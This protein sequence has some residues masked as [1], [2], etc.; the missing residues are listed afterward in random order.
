MSEE[1]IYSIDDI[2]LMLDSLLKEPKQWWDGY[3]SDRSRECPFFVNIPDE[4]LDFYFGDGRMKRGRVLE[5]GCGPGRNAI[6]LA[7][8]GCN[9]DAVDISSQAIQWAQ[10]RARDSGLEI[11]FVCQS[12]F[13]L[14]VET[15]T[16]DIVYD[17]GCFHH[18]PPH[19]RMSYIELVRNALKPDGL[20]GLVCF[21]LEGGFG[22]S[23]WEVYR[24]R[25]LGGGLGYSEERLWRTFERQFEILEFRR[26][27]EMESDSGLFGKAFLW[28]ILMRQRFLSD[29]C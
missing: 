4:N 29:P 13:D 7:R 1:A 17:S 27:K 10:E 8:Q 21:T 26:M 28:A 23:D 5:L 14:Q 11:N 24:Q 2:L 9:V 6:Y 15:S 12:V 19:R 16:Y 25:R 22:L 20:F 18:I 3:Y